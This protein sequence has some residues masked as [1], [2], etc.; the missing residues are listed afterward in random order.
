M[1]LEYIYLIAIEKDWFTTEKDVK[2]WLKENKENVMVI[3]RFSYN[4]KLKMRK[5]QKKSKK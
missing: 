5:V 2:Y 1:R 4:K 3:D